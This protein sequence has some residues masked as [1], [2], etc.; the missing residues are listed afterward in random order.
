[1]T[2]FFFIKLLLNMRKTQTPIPKGIPTPEMEEKVRCF[3]SAKDTF[4]IL[5]K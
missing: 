2:Y 1:M 3:I 5:R 4:Q